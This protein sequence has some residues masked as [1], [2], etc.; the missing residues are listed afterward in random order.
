MNKLNLLFLLFIFIA[1]RKDNDV[2]SGNSE[3]TTFNIENLSFT[4]SSNDDVQNDK[5]ILYLDQKEY[6]LV[7][8]IVKHQ[9]F[10]NS[11]FLYRTNVVSEDGSL[12]DGLESTGNN[13]EDFTLPDDNQL[14]LKGKIAKEGKYKFTIQ[15]KDE[16]GKEFFS[17]SFFVEVKDRPFYVEEDYSD[18]ETDL[19]NIFVDDFC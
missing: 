11:R 4:V 16:A 5:F 9:N 13:Y 12:D 8:K 7:G 18:T 15:F 2:V 6:N 10:K 3:D 1:C 17:K 14:S 19:S